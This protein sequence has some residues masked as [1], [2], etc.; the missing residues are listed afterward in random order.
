[1]TELQVTFRADPVVGSAQAVRQLCEDEIS[2]LEGFLTP[3]DRFHI[4]MDDL[5]HEKGQPRSVD[6][7]LIAH[8]GRTDLVF[9]HSAGVRADPP[10]SAK[11]AVHE[12]FRALGRRLSE[13]T[14]PPNALRS[15]TPATIIAADTLDAS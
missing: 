12:V 9:V 11:A 5:H 3:S 7:R 15:G 10:A 1:M 13:R 14:R 6:A 8:V 2:R 4:V